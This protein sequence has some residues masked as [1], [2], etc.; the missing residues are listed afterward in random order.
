MTLDDYHINKRIFPIKKGNMH[1]NYN[2]KL[3]INGNSLA[4]HLID[5]H[6]DELVVFLHGNYECVSDYRYSEYLEMTSLLKKDFLLFEYRGYGLSEGEPSIENIIKDI[7]T[8][9]SIYKTKYKRVWLWGR[10]IGAFLGLTALRDSNSSFGIILESGTVYIENLFRC[11]GIRI[12]N[13]ALTKKVEYYRE[14]ISL[15]AQSNVHFMIFHSTNDVINPYYEIREYA[16]SVNKLLVIKFYDN[17]S[18][19]D[20]FSTHAKHIIPIMNECFKC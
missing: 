5:N 19:N 13:M 2:L 12:E 1:I 8:V 15:C 11:L 6:S 16:K 20:M 7:E 4:N 17:C 10:S 3:T 14:C 9:V 18:H